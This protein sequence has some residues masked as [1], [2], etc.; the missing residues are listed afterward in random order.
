MEVECSNV[1]SLP[2]TE[3]WSEGVIARINVIYQ[4]D[5]AA[6]VEI[7]RNVNTKVSFRARFLQLKL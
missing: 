7:N 6:P 2:R 1:W 4:I 3:G 5:S